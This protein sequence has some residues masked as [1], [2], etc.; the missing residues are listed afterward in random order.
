MYY[1]RIKTELCLSGAGASKSTIGRN[2][3]TKITV[4]LFFQIQS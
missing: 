2:K 1:P 4:L 3:I